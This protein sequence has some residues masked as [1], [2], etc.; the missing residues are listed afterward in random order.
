MYIQYRGFKVALNSRIYDFQ[1]L[2]ATRGPREFTV[3]IQSDTDLWVSLK[4][5]D[6]P[7]ICFERLEQ[8]LGRETSTACA[9]LNLRINEQD[10]RE[11]LARHYPVVKTTRGKYLPELSTD[12]LQGPEIVHVAES[13]VPL[14]EPGIDPR[15]EVVTAI[16]LHKAGEAMALLKLALE[17]QSIQVRW[18]TTVQEALPLL[19]AASPPHLVFTQAKLPD[20]T[21]TD[22][23]KQARGA[24]K[25]AKVIVVS[26]L[27]DVRLYVDTIEGGAFDFIVP[28]LSPNE[29]AHVVKCAVENVLNLRH[30]RTGAN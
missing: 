1:V 21:W 3:K 16:L 7:G 20:G 9:D 13:S 28:P 18:M 23:V 14:A 27:A 12:S 8:E 15:K 2:D 26:R 11:Y 25:P 30:A 6:G 19:Q 24:R 10:I 5:Q 22:I 17:S 4:L 29:L